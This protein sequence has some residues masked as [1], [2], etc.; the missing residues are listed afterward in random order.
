MILQRRLKIAMAIVCSLVIIAASAGAATIT[1][2]PG[3]DLM[4]VQPDCQSTSISFASDPIPGDFF[5]PGSDPFI[6]RVYLQ[7][8][9][10]TTTPPSA[11]D[12]TDCII[13]RLDTAALPA[14]GSVDQVPIELVA[15]SLQSCA[16]VAVTYGT[17][18]P[19]E[20][21]E[22]RQL[23]F[24]LPAPGQITL[25]RECDQ[26]GTF[27]IEI[28]V[29]SQLQFTRVVPPSTDA[30]LL[31]TDPTPHL[32]QFDGTWSIAPPPGVVPVQSD[33]TVTVDHDGN[34]G[35]P[36]IPVLPTNNDF[37]VGSDQLPCSPTETSICVG[38]KPIVSLFEIYDYPGEYNLSSSIEV[39]MGSTCLPDNSCVVTDPSCAATLGGTY[40]GDGTYCTS[41][42]CAIPDTTH[43]DALG[44]FQLSTGTGSDPNEACG[45][46]VT[47]YS[48]PLHSDDPCANRVILLGTT[49]AP[50]QNVFG[51]VVFSLTGTTP[52]GSPITIKTRD[53]V[54]S[55]GQVTLGSQRPDSSWEVY[56]SF[57]IWPEIDLPDQG[58][59]L[60]SHVAM[61][62]IAAGAAKTN[63]L[64]LL[65]LEGS[66]LQLFDATTDLPAGWLCG[67]IVQPD[68]EVD[69]TQP[70][71]IGACCTSDGGCIDGLTRAD[72]QQM[73]GIY[74][75]DNSTCATATCPSDWPA[76]TLTVTSGSARVDSCVINPWNAG[77]C[78][79]SG[80]TP[81]NSG[82]CPENNEVVIR[83]EPGPY[84]PGQIIDVEMS[85]MSLAG[86]RPDLGGMIL[87]ESP[88]KP[89]Y[90]KLTVDS[91]DT[92]G[93]ITEARGYMQFLFEDQWPYGGDAG[94]PS[95]HFSPHIPMHLEIKLRPQDC[96][97]SSS[98]IRTDTLS[99]TIYPLYSGADSL[100]IPAGGIQFLDLPDVQDAC[101]DLSVSG[102]KV[103]QISFTFDSA[104]VPNSSWG[105]LD[106]DQATVL[107]NAGLTSGYLNLYTDLGWVVQ[108]LYITASDGHPSIS[109]YLQLTCQDDITNIESISCYLSVDPSPQ[110]TFGD[111][112]RTVLQVSTVEYNAE[113]A[114]DLY[115][116]FI[117]LPPD[118]GGVT[119]LPSGP[120]E[121]HTQP[122]ASN[123]QCAANQCFPMSIANSVQYL[124]NRYGLPVPNY[125]GPGL[126]GDST[127]VGQLDSLSNRPATSRTDGSG[128]W[129]VPMV[130]GKF[131]YMHENGLEHKIVC[132]HQGYG[133]GGAGNQLP[134]GDYSAHGTTSKDTSA[135]GGGI[136]FDWI[137]DQIKRGEDV[138]VVLTYDDSTGTPTAGHAVRIFECGTILGIP[139]LGY[140][141][142]QQQTNQH[143]PHDSLGL[144][145]VR[146]FV[147]D[148][149]GDGLLNLGSRD[150]EIRFAFSESADNDED[151]ATDGVDNAPGEY[152][153][154]QED[155]NHDGI[156]DVLQLPVDENVIPPFDLS[157]AN[158]PS[159]GPFD[160]TW[161]ANPD[162]KDI[163]FVG[164]ATNPSPTDSARVKV[165]FDYY[166]DQGQEVILPS[167]DTTYLP[168]NATREVFGSARLDFCPGQV[169][170]HFGLVDGMVTN[171]GGTLHHLCYPAPGCCI[172]IRG[173]V[174]N[175]A[176][177][178]IDISDVI[179]LVDYSFSG[180]PA[181]ACFEEADVNGDLSVDIEDIIYLVEYSFGD[182]PAPIAC[183]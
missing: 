18:N 138:E 174:N 180:G 172:G 94:D 50:G 176:D 88:S 19:E 177:D 170:V 143:D 74:G 62:A 140:V 70:I 23:G 59:T 120:T 40:N 51:S 86:D 99:S 161:P 146:Q 69:C 113:G 101:W 5:G 75:G 34:P 66:Q 144:K 28:M 81:L 12:L 35:T 10:L 142:D 162:H 148:I 48:G 80:D 45:D 122:N 68:F 96:T 14:V 17:G 183:P 57:D 8:L 46:A 22:V 36:E 16:P 54:E 97:P 159:F 165:Y 26:G 127:L 136:S 84:T 152:N 153:P 169:S 98:Y 107:G 13:H 72:C 156:G 132:K 157:G 65:P 155:A 164:S 31:L 89:S 151:G 85:Q 21:W 82:G 39:P 53:G 160:N 29:P 125:H 173:N 102:V 9:P 124:E 126:K 108:N 41:I 77:A 2:E 61:T 73:N 95:I 3:A 15:L 121:I 55:S 123:V 134:P 181:P 93:N 25:T 104:N 158:E 150:R 147:W 38:L 167:R 1:I 119:F 11:F 76:Y 145:S 60:I 78:L 42:V 44:D 7:A 110:T 105:E 111:G 79:S 135:A 106:V 175:D 116:T 24:G 139:F 118:P 37:F 168:P 109:T 91:V 100:G 43:F 33:G 20:Q 56:S 30:P 128:V 178:N 112:P 117:G 64:W 130:S 27:H 47:S 52:D 149:D 83:R 129:F 71:P 171:L 49:Y 4:T 115:A 141:H 166:N 182:G 163:W 32:F 114:G 67:L 92:D 6:G 58:I 87:R 133:Y 90:G 131:E 179:Y 103:S 63:E 137:C 154:G